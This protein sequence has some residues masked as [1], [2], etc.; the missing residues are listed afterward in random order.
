MDYYS[1]GVQL[2]AMA[3]TIVS[4]YTAASRSLLSP[5]FGLASFVPWTLMAIHADLH[6]LHVFNVSVLLLHT[7]TYNRWKKEK[8]QS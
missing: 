5:L 8:Q 6:A 2:V 3:M 1:I 4:I 7:R